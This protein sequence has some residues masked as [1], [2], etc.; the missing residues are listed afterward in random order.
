MVLKEVII[1]LAVLALI[2]GLFAVIAPS[3]IKNLV[4]YFTKKPVSYY[5]K[6]GFIELIIAV[7]VLAV[8]YYFL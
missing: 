5:R 4:K 8:A 1:V 6:V 3:Q 2:E 7:V